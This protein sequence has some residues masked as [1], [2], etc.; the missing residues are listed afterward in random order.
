MFIQIASLNAKHVPCGRKLD[1]QDQTEI[2]Q[3]EMH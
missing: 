3:C 2:I 1:F